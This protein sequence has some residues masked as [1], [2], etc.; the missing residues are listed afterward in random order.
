MYANTPWLL[1]GWIPYVSAIGALWSLILLIL[2]MK[3]TQELTIGSALLVILVPLVLF[4][5]LV[6]LGAVVIAALVSGF[7]EMMPFMA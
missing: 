7:V 6:I 5:V 4:L 2:G 1:L 3:E